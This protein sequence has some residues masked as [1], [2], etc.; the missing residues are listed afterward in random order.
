VRTTKGPVCIPPV[1]LGVKS[2]PEQGLTARPPV[3]ARVRRSRGKR[4]TP[5]AFR[6]TP[7]ACCSSRS[8]RTKTA[9]NKTVCFVLSRFLFFLH[10]VLFIYTLC[11]KR[12]YWSEPKRHTDKD[13]Q[14][15]AHPTQKKTQKK[16]QS[17]QRAAAANK[18]VPILANRR[19][20][21]DGCRFCC[22][23]ACLSICLQ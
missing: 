22:I 13:A 12:K 20:S 5:A 11:V 17:T 1:Q 21:K 3:H 10:L 7:R 6:D 8:G 9:K 23:Y 19:A 4:P 14:K 15:K 18:L 16:T 2:A